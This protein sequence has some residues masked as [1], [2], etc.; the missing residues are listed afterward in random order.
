MSPEQAIIY[1][2]RRVTLMVSVWEEI[3]EAPTWGNLEKP[4]Q[5]Y[6]D[7]MLPK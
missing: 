3:T 6:H 7:I 4:K 1:E 2:M 5:I